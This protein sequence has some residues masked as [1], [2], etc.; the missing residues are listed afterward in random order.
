MTQGRNTC[1]VAAG[2]ADAACA[3]RS[4]PC[5]LGDVYGRKGDTRSA[6]N[7]GAAAR[8]PECRGSLRNDRGVPDRAVGMPAACRQACQP[9][10]LRSAT[11][12]PPASRKTNFAG[13]DLRLARVI[14]N[15]PGRFG[16]R[17]RTVVAFAAAIPTP[18]RSKTEAV[19]PHVAIHV[20]RVL[21]SQRFDIRP[22]AAQRLGDHSL[23]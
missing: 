3:G 10:R 2:D 21:V 18:R 16:K 22:L 14:L 7:A 4:S 9:Q 17:V 13:D 20:S 12:R 19:A 11:G 23:M 6:M 5:P 1:P 8:P 15:F